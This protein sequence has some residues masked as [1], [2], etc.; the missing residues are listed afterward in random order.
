MKYLILNQ[1]GTPQ[2]CDPDSVGEYLSEFLMDPN[3]ISLP[4]PFRDIL[5]KIGIVPRRKFSSAKKYQKIWQA[6][7]SPLAVHTSDLQKKLQQKLGSEWKVLIGMRYAQ[8]SMEKAFNQVDL[9]QVDR[10]VFL[11][12]YPHYSKAT[13]GSATEKLNSLNTRFK[14][15][16]VREFYKSPWYISAL[17]EKIKQH[18]KPQDH[19]LLSYHGLPISQDVHNGISYQQQCLETSKLL[20]EYLELSDKQI[21]TGFQSRVGLNKWLEPST[22]SVATKLAQSGVKHLKVACPSFVADC[23][24]TLEEIGMEL[25]HNFSFS[26]GETFELIPCLNAETSLVDGLIS[27]IKA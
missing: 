10:A 2:G 6:E 19:L 27:E 21:S 15:E 4:R 22:E 12:L 3:V 20:Q 11:P 7:G 9:K 13:V 26:G 14:V 5:V 1:I 23:L 25:K 17:G 16:I 8:P 18:L 24:E